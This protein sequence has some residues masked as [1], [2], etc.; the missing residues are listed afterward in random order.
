MKM[1][2][3]NFASLQIFST[4]TWL[5]LYQ[6]KLLHHMGNHNNQQMSIQKTTTTKK[7]EQTLAK[8]NILSS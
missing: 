6:Y 4:K 1:K 5:I 8:S 2:M 7:N 3:L